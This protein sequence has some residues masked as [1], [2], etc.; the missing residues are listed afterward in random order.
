MH[1]QSDL[2]KIEL[3]EYNSSRDGILVDQI[4][5]RKIDPI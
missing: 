3:I 5:W 1:T 4:D 2:E